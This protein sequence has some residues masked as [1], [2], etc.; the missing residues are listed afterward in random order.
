MGLSK[1]FSYLLAVL[2]LLGLGLGLKLFIFD[3]GTAQSAIRVDSFPR[4]TVF[5]NDRAVGQTPYINEKIAAGQY[6]VKIDSWQTKIKL[7]SGTLAY[8][9]RNIG[10]SEDQSSGQVLTLEPL[11]SD[12]TTELAVVSNPDK[13]KVFLDGLDQGSAPLV[14]RNLT[15][16]DHEITIS[17]VGYSD[18]VIHSKIISGFRLNAMVKLGILSGS[19]ATGS[20]QLRPTSDLIASF[21][22][23]E[24]TKPYVVIKD[25]PTGFLRMRS[26]PSIT[27]TEVGQVKPSEKYP[28]LSEIAGWVKI[29]LPNIFGWV[30][31]QY[32]DK[33]K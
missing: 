30:S 3:S 14:L 27:A 26:D 29:K 21:S 28:L 7:T 23:S 32:V 10:L 15:A 31:D 16:G 19:L 4:S 25:T 20:G 5:I 17:Q 12:K 8:L 2:I 18:E 22:G 13:A 9:S 33:I 1:K 24:L 11:S 6:T